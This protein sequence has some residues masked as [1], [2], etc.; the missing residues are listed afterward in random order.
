MN[1][2]F[3]CLINLLRYLYRSD[4]VFMLFLGGNELFSVTHRA[5]RRFNTI[6]LKVLIFEGYTSRPSLLS[7]VG[8]SKY[9]AFKKLITLIF[10][11]L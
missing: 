6:P 5:C 4:A 9:Y 3:D 11:C 1:S 2:L 8:V 10:T 7:S